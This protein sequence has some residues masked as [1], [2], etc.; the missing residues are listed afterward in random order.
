LFVDVSE[1]HEIVY[2]K[3]L[4]SKEILNKIASNVP[5][6]LC[7]NKID[8]VNVQDLEDAKKLVD[9]VFSG[10][11]QVSLSALKHENMD[12]VLQQAYQKINNNGIPEANDS[13]LRVLTRHN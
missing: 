4:A 12:S 10:I 9:R 5:I 2:R 13:Q 8:R 6:I 11:P 7:L 1:D 3:I